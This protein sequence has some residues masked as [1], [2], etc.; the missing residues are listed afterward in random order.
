MNPPAHAPLKFPRFVSAGLGLQPMERVPARNDVRFRDREYAG[1]APLVR[2]LAGRTHDGACYRSRGVIVSVQTNSQLL[3]DIRYNP[4]HHW[5]DRKI[6]ITYSNALGVQHFQ[7]IDRAL[8]AQMYSLL[9]LDDD[10]VH[11]ILVAMVEAQLS[12]AGYGYQLAASERQQASP[13]SDRIGAC[14]HEKIV[15][16][17]PTVRAVARGLA[18]RMPTL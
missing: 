12:G 3:R 9:A 17:P 15:G 11:A 16:L 6:Y 13:F 8:Q 4:T 14:E 18:V 7:V 2:E 10:A 5:G 1:D